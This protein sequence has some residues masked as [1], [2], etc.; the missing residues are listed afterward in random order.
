M[1]IINF[2]IDW[3]K[4]SDT[5]RDHKRF[6]RA[7]SFILADKSVQKSNILRDPMI[8]CVRPLNRCG[9]NKLSA[10]KFWVKVSSRIL[11]LI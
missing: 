9:V 4:I 2:E 8:R 7:V 5:F 1:K 6:K 3:D 10:I 11:E